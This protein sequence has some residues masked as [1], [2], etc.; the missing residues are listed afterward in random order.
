VAVFFFAIWGGGRR[1]SGFV[2][3]LGGGRSFH[4]VFGFEGSGFDE[5]PGEER[6]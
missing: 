4:P 6:Q 3:R 5:V 2:G 1:R